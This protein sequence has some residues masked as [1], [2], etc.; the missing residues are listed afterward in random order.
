M[1]LEC[2]HNRYRSIPEMPNIG[3]NSVLIRLSLEHTPIPALHKFFCCGQVII[4]HEWATLPNYKST[5]AIIPI[6]WWATFMSPQ[7]ITGFDWSNFFRYAR[8]SA[9]HCCRYCNLFSPSPALGTSANSMITTRWGKASLTCS[10]NIVI[11]IFSKNQPPFIVV[12]LDPCKAGNYYMCWKG[13]TVELDQII[14][15]EKAHKTI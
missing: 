9:S 7:Q 8:K 6:G 4:T 1:V 15:F 10:S 2:S 14:R 11:I 5:P 3:L 13:E 12:L